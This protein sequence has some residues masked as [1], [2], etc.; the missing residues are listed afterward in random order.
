MQSEW[1]CFILL[2]AHKLKL[3][4]RESQ[5]GFLQIPLD[6]LCGTFNNLRCVLLLPAANASYTVPYERFLFRIKL[7]CI[8]QLFKVYGW[9]IS[10]LVDVQVFR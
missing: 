1:L 8:I 2:S 5:I 9:I 10:E 4:M 3:N 6:P 7:S